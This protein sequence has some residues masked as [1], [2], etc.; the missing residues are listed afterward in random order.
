M[1]DSKYKKE[2]TK[3]LEKTL[4]DLRQAKPGQA[5]STLKRLGAPPGTED[6]GFT[7][8]SHENLFH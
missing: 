8:P 4:G 5:F 6:T 1:F 3:Y 2:A 7:L